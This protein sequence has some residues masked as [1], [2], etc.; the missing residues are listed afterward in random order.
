MNGVNVIPA[1]YANE[2]IG[3]WLDRLQRNEPHAFEGLYQT[4]SG[5]VSFVCTKFCDNKEDAEEVVQ[6]TFV[7]AFKKANDLRSDTLLA[8]L[9]KI[10]VRECF[11]R[12]KAN[13]RRTTYQFTTDEMPAD[14][15]ELDQNLLPEEALLNK[16]RQNELLVEISKLPQTQ[17]EMIYLYYYINFTAQQ[18]AELMDCNVNYVCLNLFRARK[19][20]KRKMG[21]TPALTAT[22][23]ILLPLAALFLAEET[24]YA[25]TYTY[26]TAAIAAGSTA[27]ILGSSAAA[28]TAT[29]YIA[30]ACTAFVLAAT[31]TL[32]IA[33]QPEPYAYP[34]EGQ[35]LA[36]PAT[37]QAPPVTTLPTTYP[38][39]ATEV[40]TVPTT[41]PPP[42][43][44]TVPTTTPPPEVPTLPTTTAPP[45]PEAPP[46][47][48]TS[49]APIDRTQNAL[50]ALAAATTQTEV[51]HLLA[52]Y[53]FV[54]DQ[55]ITTLAD[56]RLDFYR[57]NE[58]SGDI[59]VG[60]AMEADGSNWRKQ[61][62][63]AEGAYAIYDHVDLYRWMMH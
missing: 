19:S 18:I 28:G 29:G 22:G 46:S 55:H 9:R 37:T 25:A 5:Y 57:F 1:H 59:L 47:T 61:Y 43:V 26:G 33:L 6:D 48:T 32:Y 17:R 34:V 21:K 42:E 50:A 31:V 2:E 14:L 7:I 41:T 15:H 27:G 54:F 24:A 51:M 58:G 40:P 3:Y 56:V 62:L 30:A 38:P 13:S 44:P 11:R 60:M 23:I 35:A 8:Y 16:E 39:P 63:F 4:C 36:A 52:Y 12:R 20:I 53:G 49:P 10:A 45:A